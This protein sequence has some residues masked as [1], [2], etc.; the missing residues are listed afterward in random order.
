ME[1]P[2]E[3]YGIP[4]GLGSLKAL[5]GNLLRKS[6]RIPHGNQRQF[7]KEITGDPSRKTIKSPSG[8]NDDSS[9]KSMEI[10]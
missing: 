9:G 5:N 4:Q 10:P 1:I 2:Q 6:I 8:I 7:L 3:V